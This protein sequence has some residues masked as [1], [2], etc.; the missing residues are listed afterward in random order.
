M[1][2]DTTCLEVPNQAES[3]DPYLKIKQFI[4]DFHALLKLGEKIEQDKEFG[5]GD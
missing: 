2:D 1:Y 4:D 5:S 3:D